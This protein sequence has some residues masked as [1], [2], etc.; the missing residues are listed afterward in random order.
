MEVA[1]GSAGPRRVAAAR[2]WLGDL[3]VL[4]LIAAVVVSER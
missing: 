3:A 4:F 1:S 2:A